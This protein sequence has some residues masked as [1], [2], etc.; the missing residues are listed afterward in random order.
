MALF[1]HENRQRSDRS[2]RLYARYELIYTCVDFGAAV[3]F[4]IGSVLLFWNS[5]E[6]VAIC[7]FVVGSLLFAAKPTIRMLR[8]LKLAAMG[9]DEDLAERYG[10]G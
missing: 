5:L 2:R 4:A 9:D 7:F 6:T 3:A 8:E 10:S 1:R